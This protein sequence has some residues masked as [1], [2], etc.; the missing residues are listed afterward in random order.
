MA[1][2]TLLLPQPFGPTTAVI[3]VPNCISVLSAKDLKPK[4][5]SFRKIM[6]NIPH[7]FAVKQNISKLNTTIH[8]LV[9]LFKIQ[10]IEPT[11][12]PC[13]VGRK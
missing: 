9:N 13:H 2:T 12:K 1:S 3:P 11:I 5:E 6:E 4:M 10:Y 7:Y 8:C